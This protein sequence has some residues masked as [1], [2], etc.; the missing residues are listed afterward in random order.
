LRTPA[1]FEWSNSL[2]EN[3]Y[4]PGYPFPRAKLEGR[5]VRPE[6]RHPSRQSL[7]QS[8]LAGSDYSYIRAF[9]KV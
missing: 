6:L 7:I 2:D 5:C 9:L 3:R 4:R 1:E 8:Q